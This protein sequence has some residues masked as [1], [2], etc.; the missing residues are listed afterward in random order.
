MNGARL[1][2][3]AFEE[4]VELVNPTHPD[5][6]SAPIKAIG[7]IKKIRGLRQFAIL[8]TLGQTRGQFD[9]RELI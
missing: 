2:S 7:N 6:V 9:A 5:W 3:V 8:G 4:L 1:G